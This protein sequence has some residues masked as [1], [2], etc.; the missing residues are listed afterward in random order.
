MS[1]KQYVIFKLKNEEYGIEIT[2]VEEILKYQEIT[3][4]P[5]ADSYIL[6]VVNIRG[7]VIPVYNLKKKFYGED[8][9]VTEETRIVV[10]SFQQ[11]SIGMIVDSVSE[12]LRIPN[13]QVDQTSA[14]FSEDCNK[15][16]S[17]I[18]KLA[19]RLLMILD[20]SHL[21]SEK[22]KQVIQEVV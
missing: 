16:I 22:E 4:V 7:K 8:C 13:A 5:Q 21:F 6:G 11:M 9:Q 19:N 18:G 20:I 2:A 12:V 17:G 3:K 14:I 15:S 1:E 10:I